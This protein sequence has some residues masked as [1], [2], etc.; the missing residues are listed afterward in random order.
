MA[1][2]G[3]TDANISK[4]K[5]LSATEKASTFFVSTEE[6]QL[7]TNKAKGILGPGWYQVSSKVTNDGQK[8]EFAE[9]IVALSVLNATS[10]DAADDTIVADVELAFTT[11]PVSVTVVAPAVA[12]FIVAVTPA[13]GAT[14]QWQEKIGSSV[15]ANVVD[16]GVFSG[17][18]TATLAIS[19]STGLDTHRYR[20]IVSNA[21]ATAQVTSKGATL[22]VTA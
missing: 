21:A 11:Q 2:F 1:L 9:C 6:A 20:C 10:G 18:T 4:P 3:K 8:R 12:S 14:Y 22:T 13:P 5:W 16:A 19:D 17:A 15:Y 7:A